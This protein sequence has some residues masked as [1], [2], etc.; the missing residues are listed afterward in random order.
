[1]HQVIAKHSKIL[2]ALVQYFLVSKQLFA[3][4]ILKASSRIHYLCGG[5]PEVWLKFSSQAI[6]ALLSF[7][8][9]FPGQ[10]NL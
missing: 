1:M 5:R 4:K 10:S 6:L 8:G 3:K 7:R 2:F 9:V